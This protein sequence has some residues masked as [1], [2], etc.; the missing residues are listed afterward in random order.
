MLA[1]GK[2]AVVRLFVAVFVA[3]RRHFIRCPGI[4]DVQNFEHVHVRKPQESFD[5]INPGPQGPSITV[6]F[7]EFREV[8]PSSVDRKK[9]TLV[10]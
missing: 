1:L 3:V 6:I 4:N 5:S 2:V 7:K 9:F 8:S 10:F